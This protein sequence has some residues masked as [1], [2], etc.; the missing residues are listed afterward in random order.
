MARDPSESKP[1]RRASST[2]L[3][4]AANRFVGRDAELRELEAALGSGA[5]WLTLLGPPGIGKTRLAQEL[6]LRRS[7]ARR[8]SVRWCSCAH[9]TSAADVTFGMAEALDAPVGDGTPETICAALAARG[10]TLLVL[11]GVE[12]VREQVARAIRT[13]LAACPRLQVLVTSRIAL[14]GPEEQRWMVGGMPWSGA[15]AGEDV[16]GSDAARL[17]VDRARL[18]RPDLAPSLGAGEIAAIVERLEGHPLAIEI[19]ASRAAVFAP[20]EILEQL[21]H[22]D[23]SLDAERLCTQGDGCAVICAFLLLSS[24]ARAA[25]GQ[26]TV[27]RRGFELAA[28]EAVVGAAAGRAQAMAWLRELCDHS[29]VRV[30][31]GEGDGRLRY[32]MLELVRDVAGWLPAD[33]GAGRRRHLAYYR[34]AAAAR[35]Q[36]LDATGDVE[37]LSWL[38]RERHNL[39]AALE[40]AQADP[41]GAEAAVEMALA[42]HAVLEPRGAHAHAAGILR[43][44]LDRA[45]DS[46]LAAPLRVRALCA[47][48]IAERSGGNAGHGA[49]ALDAAEALVDEA[50]DDALRGRVWRLRAEL[51][52]DAG[53]VD[54]AGMACRAGLS[55][56][57][58]GG[59]RREAARTLGTLAEARRMAG[60]LDEAQRHLLQA[61]ELSRSLPDRRLRGW[62]EGT[63]AGVYLHA[64]RLLEARARAEHAITLLEEAGEGRLAAR[65][66]LTSALVH[67][68][69][70]EL[71]AAAQRYARAAQAARRLGDRHLWGLTVGYGATAMH[72]AGDGARALR[73]Y[74]ESLSLLETADDLLQ[75]GLLGA[76]RATLLAQLGDVDMAEVAFA[77]AAAR[78]SATGSAEHAPA[79]AAHRAALGLVRRVERG[80][81]LG[82]AHAAMQAAMDAARHG[83][84]EARLAARLLQRVGEAMRRDVDRA[85]GDGLLLVDDGSAFRM[86]DGEPVDLSRRPTLRRLLL[87]LARQRL[88]GGR[89]LDMDAMLAAGWPGERAHYDAARNRLHVAVHALRKLGLGSHL[90]HG[91]G[92]HHL[93]PHLPVRFVRALPRASGVIAA[94]EWHPAAGAPPERTGT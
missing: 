71:D 55:A 45:G 15:P 16:L 68:E 38:L 89:A 48:A 80:G 19:A 26:L 83:G 20:A 3:P 40:T 46:T 63:L 60:D 69:L 12:H 24:S 70:G 29:L 76:A 8:G 90:R 58:R 84:V 56:C 2:T 67:Q 11:D 44:A 77:M 62:L 81:D 66:A 91:E 61:L 39:H 27:F 41:L 73:A 28:Y 49:A 42:L 85:P 59:A 25:L 32:G 93:D 30:E 86:P 51:L 88:R 74:D 87:A 7:A 21:R 53:E 72:E 23:A 52:A 1:R 75:A 78:I 17:F 10:R 50:R 33:R 36:A 6:G 35:L 31:D 13:W 34:A 64:G 82:G 47:L 4:C 43:G 5:R 9:A 79:L 57:E 18:A 14:G 92:G 54:A 37:P 22:P 94:V 65:F